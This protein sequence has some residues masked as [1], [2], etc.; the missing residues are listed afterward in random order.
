VGA[1]RGRVTKS[2]SA[3]PGEDAGSKTRGSGAV[4]LVAAFSDD[5]VHGAE[6]EPAARQGAIDRGDAERQDAM[7]G[8]LLDL[9]DALAKR[10]EAGGGGHTCGNTFIVLMFPFCSNFRRLSI[11]VAFPLGCVS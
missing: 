8:R 2:T 4:F 5:L 6:R 9:S 7:P 10:A 1:E 11:R 3:E